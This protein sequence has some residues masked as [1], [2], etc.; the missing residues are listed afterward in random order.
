MGTIN[1]SWFRNFFDDEHCKGANQT[2]AKKGFISCGL[3]LVKYKVAK[4]HNS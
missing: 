2:I 3:N 4:Y 1:Q